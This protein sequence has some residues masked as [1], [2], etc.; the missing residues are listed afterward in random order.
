MPPDSSSWSPG[1]AAERPAFRQAASTR[2]GRT[3]K[4]NGSL[5]AR[6]PEE[7]LTN[8][9]PDPHGQQ[10]TQGSNA[11]GNMRPPLP[12]SPPHHQHGGRRSPVTMEACDRNRVPTGSGGLPCP[13]TLPR[14][15]GH[16]TPPTPVV[17]GLVTPGTPP[18]KDE[19]NPSWKR[20]IT[21]PSPPW[22]PSTPSA[23]RAPHP[24]T[25]VEACARRGSSN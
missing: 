16:G 13:L 12:C 14:L 8:R 10:G 9:K 25:T 5:A 3:L 11:P 19:W 4:Y 20:W 21:R 6:G 18:H 22:H 2:P 23:W 7:V 24:C 1:C 17:T 15:Q